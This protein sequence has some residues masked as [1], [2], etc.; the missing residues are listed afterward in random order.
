[1]KKRRLQDYYQI[2]KNN[3]LINN[4]YKRL[5]ELDF[6][7]QK[8]SDE[9]KIIIELI[10]DYAK[11]ND[12][13]LLKYSLYDNDITNFVQMIDDIKCNTDFEF[14]DNFKDNNSFKNFRFIEFY[15]YHNMNKNSI[16]KEELITDFDE[17]IVNVNGV[18]Y[19]ISN[20]LDVMQDYGYGSIIERFEQMKEEIANKRYKTFTESNRKLLVFEV[21]QNSTMLDYFDI[22]INNT[23]NKRL[24]KKLIQ[25][26]YI[27]IGLHK[28]L[29]ESFIKDQN[30]YSKTEEYQNKYKSICNKKDPIFKAFNDSYLQVLN[31]T[32]MDIGC[33]KKYAYKNLQDEFNDILIS[34]YLKTYIS[35]LENAKDI[36][37]ISTSEKYLL[38]ENNNEI[39]KKLFKQSLNLEPRLILSRKL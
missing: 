7:E 20:F 1:M 34:I 3:E 35:L 22:E 25:A 30:N 16:K 31:A 28:D 23:N 27:L 14:L 32:I 37:N 29:E 15:G 8:Q 26:K 38:D 39:N 12:D 13:L 11:I 33:R 4:L 10:N 24:K 2:I 5:A 19:T 6:L 9:Y 21:L 17:A 36:F 18:K